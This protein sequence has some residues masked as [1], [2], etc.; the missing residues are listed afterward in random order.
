MKKIFNHIYKKRNA[1]QYYITFKIPFFTLQ[2]WLKTFT[3]L[4]IHSI[5]D[6]WRYGHSYTFL[7]VLQHHTTCMERNLVISTKARYTFHLAQ[8]SYF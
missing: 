8:Q 2:H 3:S 6:V 1:T 4:I 5:E 7:V